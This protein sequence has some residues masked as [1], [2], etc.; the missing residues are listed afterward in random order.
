MPPL[1]AFAD[2]APL[3][4][5]SVVLMAPPAL[6][7]ARQRRSADAMLPWLSARAR[8]CKRVRFRL[9]APQ[10]PARATRVFRAEMR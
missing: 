3:P 7:L 4:A 9:Q 10:T 1:A 8:M 2:A 5:A 6:T